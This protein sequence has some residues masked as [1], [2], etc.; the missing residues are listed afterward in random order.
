LVENRLQ[1]TEES[2]EN[3]GEP[4]IRLLQ[5]TEGYGLGMD[6]GGLIIMAELIIIFRFPIRPNAP[7]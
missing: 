2:L 3:Q 5:V 7:T 6:R 4:N 1:G